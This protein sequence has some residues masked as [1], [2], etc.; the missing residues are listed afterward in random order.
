[1]TI[2]KNANEQKK[3]RIMQRPERQSFMRQARD[4]A[5]DYVH[6]LV[7]PTTASIFRAA[8]EWNW[9]RPQ[10]RGNNKIIDPF[11]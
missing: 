6:C 4:R 3:K 11:Q 1:M 2:F 5:C 10:Q 9:W 8:N 7:S